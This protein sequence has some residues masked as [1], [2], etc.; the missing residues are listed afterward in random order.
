MMRQPCKNDSKTD[1]NLDI[2]P[3][4]PE[5]K[6]GPTAF[7]LRPRLYRFA[8]AVG[9]RSRLKR[10]KRPEPTRGWRDWGLGFRILGYTLA[11][12]TRQ[13]RSLCSGAFLG[14]GLLELGYQILSPCSKAAENSNE[15]KGS[16]SGPNKPRG[17]LYPD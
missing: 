16:S 5:T 13:T 17:L 12:R 1:P 10:H 14:V 4:T 9:I 7:A 11:T 8:S 6:R 2:Y 15:G 3:Y